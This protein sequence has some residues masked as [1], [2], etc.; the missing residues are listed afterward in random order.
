MRQRG[1]DHVEWFRQPARQ[2]S[3]IH[4]A[5]N[6][7]S[8]G[9]FSPDDVAEGLQTGEFLPTDLAWREPMEAWKPLGEFTDLPAV[10]PVLV[11]PVLE[12]VPVAPGVLSEPAWERRA[13]LGWF[14]AMYQ[15]VQQVFS[16]PTS[17][18]QAMKQEGGFGSPLLL[19]V[20]MLTVTTW[21]ST[22]YQIIAYRM[23]PDA[24]LGPLSTEVTPNM[25]MASL[26]FTMVAAPFFIAA[27]AFISS[28]IIHLTFTALGAAK[29]PFEATFRAVCYAMAPAS[30]LQVMPLCGGMLYLVSGLVLII[31]A[32]REVHQTETGRATA[33]VILPSLLCCGLF[34]GLYATMATFGAVQALAK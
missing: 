17:T 31:I 34:I 13:E 21:V 29:K 5:R 9:Q 30:L 1:V 3:R 12:D 10:E 14:S 33:G 11:P 6:R 8:L 24:V 16:T 28:G 18:F 25:M 15:T 20:M 27:G 23:N 7:Q 4:I 22:I 2:M 19:Y 26:I 32:L